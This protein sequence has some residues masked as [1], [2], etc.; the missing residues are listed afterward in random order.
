MKKLLFLSLCVLIDTVRIGECFSRFDDDDY[1]EFDTSFIDPHLDIQRNVKPT[2]SHDHHNHKISDSFDFDHNDQYK[3]EFKSD[4]FKTDFKDD[5]KDDFK[6][7]FKDDFKN[8][9]KYD[10]F[11][12]D[13]FKRD[14][15][16]NEFKKNDAPKIEIIKTDKPVVDNYHHKPRGVL[17]KKQ[18]K[19]EAFNKSDSPAN[20][21]N[22][23]FDEISRIPDFDFHEHDAWLDQT[24]DFEMPRRDQV[25]EKLVQ[26]YRQPTPR[27]PFR[28]PMIPVVCSSAL[29]FKKI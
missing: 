23:N 28:V 8:D 22:S 24:R 15:F 17:R 19:N 20:E 21:F 29:F 18:P 13:P 3:N 5:Y 25:S 2:T 7:E 4:T 12:N 11:R 14:Q 27:T 16:K 6:N 9:F 10:A 26:D 1:N